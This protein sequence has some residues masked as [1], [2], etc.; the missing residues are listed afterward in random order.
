MAR[1]RNTLEKRDALHGGKTT[2]AAQSRIADEF[3]A[4]ERFSDALDFFERSNDAEGMAKIKR[5]A[6]ERGDTFLLTRLERFNPQLV[7]MDDWQKAGEVA[8]QTDRPSMAQYAQKKIAGEK[9]TP[10]PGAEPSA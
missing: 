1:F 6:L 3:L 9:P 4:A 2:P 10:A 5:I 7:T 8:A